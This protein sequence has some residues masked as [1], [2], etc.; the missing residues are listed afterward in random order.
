MGWLTALGV[1]ESDGVPCFEAAFQQNVA[2]KALL[3][4]KMRHRCSPLQPPPCAC[5]PWG[6]AQWQP[7]GTFVVLYPVQW[8]YVVP[9]NTALFQLPRQTG[10]ISSCFATIINPLVSLSRRWTMLGGVCHRSTDHPDD[11]RV[12]LPG[13]F[14]FPAAG[15]T[16]SP[17]GLFTMA[18]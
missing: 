17:F 6:G 18:R 14:Q 1:P 8:G 16:T 7:D 15:W 4:S 3:H 9:V 11:T 10:K 5:G 12:H 13:A 2:V